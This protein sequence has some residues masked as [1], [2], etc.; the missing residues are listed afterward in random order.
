[1]AVL[2]IPEEQKDALK[3]IFSMTDDVFSELL[4]AIKDIPTSL[5]IYKLSDRVADHTPNIEQKRVSNVL[6][7]LLS[8][9]RLL[10]DATPSLDDLVEDVCESIEADEDIKIEF[11]PD[12]RNAFAHRL[13]QLLD[14][15]RFSVWAKAFDVLHE[16]A[17]RVASIRVL[18]DMRPVFD[19][20]AAMPPKGA[21]ITR[22]LRI[23]Y[24]HEFRTHEAFF[25]LDATDIDELIDAL[26]RAK[27]KAENLRL[28]YGATGT[29]FYEAESEE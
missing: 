20:D 24:R 29:T 16:Q 26:T 2:I 25:A 8:L 28:H 6:I 3:D 9:H 27:A 11:T 5:N 19:S 23:R 18:T 7:M 22:T 13:R 14:V 17:N 21:V 10:A 4:Q 15:E 12:T 1:M